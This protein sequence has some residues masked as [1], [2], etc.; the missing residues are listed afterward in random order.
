MAGDESGRLAL[1]LVALL[2]G[3]ADEADAHAGEQ[4]RS[5]WTEAHA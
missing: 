1:G 2:A 4:L 3:G 5:L